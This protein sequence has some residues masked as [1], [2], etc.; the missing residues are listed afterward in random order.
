M[1]DRPESTATFGISGLQRSGEMWW[2][3]LAQARHFANSSLAG[4]MRAGVRIVPTV[5][6][7]TV[8]P[9]TLLMLPTP[10]GLARE[11]VELAHP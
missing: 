4:A 7:S 10:T 9:R 3:V 11:W 5:P 2:R 1:D 8:R 6:Q